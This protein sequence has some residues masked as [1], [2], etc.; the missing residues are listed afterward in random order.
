ML[1]YTR[2]EKTESPEL[3]GQSDLGQAGIAEWGDLAV[4]GGGDHYQR[5]SVLQLF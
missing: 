1:L 3:V 2:W 4:E 5:I